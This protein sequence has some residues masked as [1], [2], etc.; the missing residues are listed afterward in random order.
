LL[1]KKL[2]LRKSKRNIKKNGL[3]K[4][5]KKKVQLKR[6]ERRMRLPKLKLFRLP[7]TSIRK[8]KL[9]N[10]LFKRLLI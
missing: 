5:N 4:I 7:S 6:T 3:M 9:K 1:K 10:L 8:N 2:I